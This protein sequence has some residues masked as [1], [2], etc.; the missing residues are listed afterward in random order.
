MVTND[1]VSQEVGTKNKQKL[2]DVALKL[3][4]LVLRVYKQKH[5]SKGVEEDGR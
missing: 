1:K 5:S 4:E 3:A 2:E